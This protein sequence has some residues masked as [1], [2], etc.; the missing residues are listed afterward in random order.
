[1]R[2]RTR[3]LRRGD[4]SG[5][6]SHADLIRLLRDEK[7]TGHG[8]PAYDTHWSSLFPNWCHMGKPPA[9]RSDWRDLVV[10]FKIAVVV[11]AAIL[12]YTAFSTPY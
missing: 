12:V 3:V 4:T 10:V 2:D 6:I 7:V 5:G 9:I 11:I 1:L 8:Q